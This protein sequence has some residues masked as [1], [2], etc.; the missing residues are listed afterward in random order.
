MAAGGPSTVAFLSEIR[1]FRG[2]EAE[3]RSITVDLNAYNLELT[4][5]HDIL[6]NG[7]I[8]GSDQDL[9][10][11]G[12]AVMA[13]S[14]IVFLQFN[15]GSGS[16][17]FD[18]SGNV[19]DEWRQ[20]G[21][22]SGMYIDSDDVLYVTDSSST[23]SNNPGFEEGIRAGSARDGL[24]TIFLDDPHEDGTQE[25]VFAD[26]D[27]NIYGSLTGGMTLRRYVPR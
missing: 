22:P 6:V 5:T 11:Y 16:T 27:G 4:G 3:K 14:P 21:R 17:A 25:G 24:V 9:T 26:R 7:N 18:Q 15:E 8:V 20:F 1:I 19:L 10:S 2:E 12:E 23:P 13:D